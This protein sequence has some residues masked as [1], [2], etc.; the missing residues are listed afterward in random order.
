MRRMFWDTWALTKRALRESMRQ[1]GLEVGN[2][3]IPLFFMAVTVG[4]IGN[5]A[6]EAFGVTDF[7]G[8]Q[9]PVAVLQGVAGI[10]G[11]AG[12]GMTRDIETG[13]YDKLRLTSAPRSSLVMSRMAADAIRAIVLTAIIIVV[14]LPFG[15]N[16]EAGVGGAIVLLIFA[17]AFGLAYSGI[18]MAIALRTGSPQAAQLGFLL[19]FPLL[20]LSPAF[21]PKSV[22]KGWLEFLATINPVT[23][24]LEGM[25]ELVLDGW[26]WEGLLKASAALAGILAVTLMLT[27]LAYQWRERNT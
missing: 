6:E 3:F 19:F 16:L 12:L 14:A 23:Y 18:G 17:G 21:A 22:F 13:Y 4:A 24:L 7:V 10:A 15:A 5:I 20:F 1:P 9:M 8:F 26:Q 27:L 25:R 11:A 2:I